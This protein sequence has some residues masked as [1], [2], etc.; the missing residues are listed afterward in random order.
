[1]KSGA[2]RGTTS[3][4]PVMIRRTRDKSCCYLFGLTVKNHFRTFVGR[5][6]NR[7]PLVGWGV[8]L[9]ALGMMTTAASCKDDPEII[10]NDDPGA[11]VRVTTSS[12]VGVLLEDFPEASRDRIAEELLAKGEDWWIERAKWQLRL[13]SPRLIYRKYY[14]DEAEWD[15]KNALPLPPEDV[16]RITVAS[17]GASRQMIDGHDVI[18]IDFEYE[19]VLVTDVDSPGV[20]E[21][22]LAEVGG[23]WDEDFVFPVDPTLLLQRTGYACMTEDQFPAESVDAEDAYRFYDDTCEQESPDEQSCHHTEPLPTEGCVEALENRVGTVAATIHYERVAWEDALAD[24]WRFGEVTTPDAPDLKV[25]TTGEG[26][27]DHRVKFKYIPPG[28][29]A[30]IE[31][32]VTGEGWR[33]LLVFD[34]HDQNVGG[35]PLHIGPVDYY[36]EGFGSELIDHNVYEISDCHNHYHFKYY[37]SFNWGDTDVQKMGFCLESTDRL[38]NNEYA[39]LYSNYVCEDQG[40]SPGWGDLYGASLTCNWVDVTDVDTS[41]GDMTED[42]TF[43]SNPEGFMCE[44]ELVKD[45][46]GNQVWEPTEF[47][48]DEGEPVDKPACEEAP[49][50]EGNDTGSVAATVPQRGGF[51][52]RACQSEH[53]LGPL[54]NCGFATD[55]EVLTCTPG[56]EVA[57]SCTGGSAEAPQA[58]RICEASAV[59]GTIDCTFENALVNGISADGSASLT[60]TCPAAR[61]GDETGGRYSI[62]T[63]A[64]WGSDD[65]LAITCAP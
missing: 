47:E 12:K 4:S 63:A 62:L 57:L 35:K 21:P 26:L 9:T 15:L 44:G 49:D 41:A 59:L 18:A 33:R 5:A 31:G 29:C 54:R 61:D 37:G 55:A 48:S 46:D 3:C 13:T 20:S 53:D 10:I 42:L 2:R 58:V 60:F 27:N 32:C 51:V 16:W 6:M 38:S 22:E 40:V 8:G 64:A 36:V 43:H 28:H 45:A 34:S 19:G 52:T 65:E 24:E 50:T 39:P 17:A 23:T 25:L 14:F 11:L 30:V 1:M 56:E 7:W